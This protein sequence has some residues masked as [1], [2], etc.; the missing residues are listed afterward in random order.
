MNPKNQQSGIE[1]LFLVPIIVLGVSMQSH[2]AGRHSTPAGAIF[3]ITL[4]SVCLIGY[5]T[6][7][8]IRLTRKQQ[9]PTPIN[10]A[11]NTPFTSN[12]QNVVMAIPYKSQ[13]SDQWRCLLYSS[14]RS[15]GG[16]LLLLGMPV[17]LGFGIAVCSYGVSS[18]A[19]LLT[20]GLEIT[21]VVFVLFSILIIASVN[22]MY[23]SGSPIRSSTIA[24]STDG[25]H[26][27]M[28]SR[29]A[30]VPWSKVRS[31]VAVGPDVYFFT[32]SGCNYCPCVMTNTPNE[33]RLLVETATE[34]WKGRPVTGSNLPIILPAPPPIFNP[35]APPGWQPPQIPGTWPPP[36]SPEWQQQPQWPQ[37]PSQQAPWPPPAASQQNPWPPQAQ[38][39]PQLPQ[40]GQ[41]PP[42]PPA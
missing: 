34:L 22:T 9:S 41:W 14:L 8:V 15:P 2:H 31:I 27:M 35:M 30:F 24:L 37:Q 5:I 28:P 42:Q 3:D 39:Q 12:P 26:D 38:Q 13:K 32:K 36:P 4:F 23:P 16:L 17:I 6:M 29:T 21:A 25:F 33:G 40:P 1:S 18:L 20:T 19:I 11:W 10:Q 7:L